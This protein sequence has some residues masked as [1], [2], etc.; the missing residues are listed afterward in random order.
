MKPALC[1]CPWLTPRPVRTAVRVVVHETELLKSTNSGRLVPLLVAGAE[2]V[3]YGS[4]RPALPAR[5]WPDDTRPVVLFPLEGAPTVDTIVDDDPRPFSL[6]VLDG[7]WHQANRLRKRFHHLRVPFVRLPADA[8]PSLYRLRRGHFG[9]SLST[10]EATARA[11]AVLDGDSRV[12]DHL[13]DGFRRMQDRTLW[14]RGAL[15]GDAVYGGLPEGLQRHDLRDAA[16]AM[17]VDEE[18]DGAEATAS[19]RPR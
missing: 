5:M 6:I 17:D 4:G 8:P 3:V 18:G 2:L 16:D 10:L 15:P 11:L 9:A 7:T 12:A 1:L 19:G 13:V 14:L